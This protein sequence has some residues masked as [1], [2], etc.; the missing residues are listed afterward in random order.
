MGLFRRNLFLNQ[1]KVG[2][3]PNYSHIETD[4]T[5]FGY[6]NATCFEDLRV[7]AISTRTGVIAPTDETGFRGDANHYVRN[8]VHNQADEIQFTVQMPHAW[9]IGTVIYPHVHFSPWTTSTGTQ[10][11]KFILEYYVSD[12]D[13]QF[14]SSPATLPL[15][16]TWSVNQ[17]WYH[18]IAGNAS[19]IDLTGYN[20]S[21]LL[22]CRLYRDN[23][24]TNN[25]AN[26]LTILYFD[27]HYKVNSLGSREEYAK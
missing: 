21:S 16:K 14:P 13:K 5:I 11:A 6:G 12:F 3:A 26:K 23:T 20:V 22:K 27:I 7:D 8:F 2:N 17:Q 15:T 25:F 10:A 24:V 1:I 4:G 19:G 18:L 9:E